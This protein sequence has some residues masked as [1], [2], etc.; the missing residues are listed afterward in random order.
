MLGEPVSEQNPKSDR[1]P[2][3][4]RITTQ[5]N[6]PSSKIPNV[7]SL[8]DIVGLNAEG[9]EKGNIQKA[10]ERVLTREQ[11]VLIETEVRIGKIRL[12]DGGKIDIPDEMDTDDDEIAQWQLREGVLDA[13][14]FAGV[15][16]VVFNARDRVPEGC[17]ADLMERDRSGEYDAFSN[18][19][20]TDISN[21]WDFL[22]DKY[23]PSWVQQN[24]RHELRHGVVSSLDQERHVQTENELRRVV[25][26]RR[27]RA[28]DPE[29]ARQLGYLDELH[30]QYFDVLEGDISG[31]SSF[32]ALDSQFYSIEDNGTHQE[33]ASSTPEGRE[34][35]KDLFLH[36][37]GLVLMKRM[38][39]QLDNRGDIDN[40]TVGAGVIIATERSLTEVDNK[41]KALWQGAMQ[42]PDIHNKFYT[43]ISSYE[44]AITGNTPVV[45]QELRDVLLTTPGTAMLEQ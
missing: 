14:K 15:R 35:A 33:V 41:V 37:Q 40:L 1:T 2:Q 39:E 5:Q 6:N 31:H 23:Q 3:K 34:A 27:L 38:N 32:R 20:F 18:T 17:P 26:Q 25:D 44:P 7:S 30:S 21:T 29:L 28:L 9:D 45:T 13:K 8:E 43:F 22:Y 12:K 24:L 11:L 36:L 4:P 16:M 19:T 10:L 42:D